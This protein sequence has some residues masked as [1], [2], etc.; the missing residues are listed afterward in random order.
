MSAIDYTA[1]DYEAVRSA[2]ISRIPDHLPEW[3][4]RS[5]NDFGIVMLEL[6]AYSCDIM[7]YYADRVAN[8]AFVGTAVL[9]SSVY[10]IARMV[11]YQPRST[12]CA[13]GTVNFTLTPNRRTEFVVPIGTLLKTPTSDPMR[14][15]YFS[16]TQ[17]YIVPAIQEA[18][19]AVPVIEGRPFDEY[20]GVGTGGVGQVVVIPYDNVDTSNL[21]VTVGAFDWAQTTSLMNGVPSGRYYMVQ[22]LPDRTYAVIFGD[23]ANGAMPAP[24]DGIRVRGYRSEGAAG[25]V[26]ANSITDIA[27]PV[28]GLT[29]VTNPQELTGGEDRET[30]D[31][32]RAS[33]PVAQQTVE[34]A[35]T[36][37]D[38]DSLAVDFP[39]IAKAQAN[40]AVYTNVTVY[41]MAVGGS[42]VPS[43]ALMLDLQN[44]LLERSLVNVS[45][46]VDPGIQVNFN[47]ALQVRASSDAIEDDV[48]RA[49]NAAVRGTLNWSNPGVNFNMVLTLS[50]IY[51]V[52]DD[53][54]GID[55]AIVTQFWKGATGGSGMSQSLQ[56]GIGEFPI[57]GAITITYII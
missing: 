18:L 44:Y 9:E 21:R 45:V 25:N 50:H 13:T 28:N 27:S 42:G 49:V 37:S 56:F 51:A 32:I 17:E 31:Q 3:K 2:L 10:D 43:A 41:V 5:P 39:G 4:S 36:L 29:G 15:I 57:A 34:R 30:V 12:Q 26:A 40:A 6:F 16:T 33:L 22:M 24:N 47:L 19:N 54:P 7:N 14:A 52:L 1:R 35:V 55:Y 46:G 48:T 11:G 8:E 38:Y 20:L 53:V 23:G